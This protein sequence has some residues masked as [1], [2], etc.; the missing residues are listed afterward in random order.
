MCVDRE[1]EIE[2]KRDRETEIQKETQTKG[3][4]LFYVL[5]ILFTFKLD[6]NK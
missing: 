5:K 3:S 2:R 4:T 1:R 6:I